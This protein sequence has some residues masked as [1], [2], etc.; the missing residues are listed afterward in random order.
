MWASSLS[1]SIEE[2][3]C[4]QFKTQPYNYD[5]RLLGRKLVPLTFNYWQRLIDI[6][7]VLFIYIFFENVVGNLVLQQI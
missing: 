3:D 2:G 5:D 7:W 4:K 1:T 6:P